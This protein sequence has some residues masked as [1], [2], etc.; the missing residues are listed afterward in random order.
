[1]RAIILSHISIAFQVLVSTYL[2]IW[3]YKSGTTHF[4]LPYGVVR[5]FPVSFRFTR[6]VVLHLWC[7]LSLS[8]QKFTFYMS[9]GLYHVFRMHAILVTPAPYPLYIMPWGNIFVFYFRK[10]DFTKYPIESFINSL[11]SVLSCSMIDGC[12]NIANRVLLWLV[13]LTSLLP[14]IISPEDHS[15]YWSFDFYLRSGRT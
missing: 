2:Q 5:F 13:C 1:M 4:S 14:D 7:L 15:Y 12:L 6:Y 3:W 9:C 10:K 11:S 8:S